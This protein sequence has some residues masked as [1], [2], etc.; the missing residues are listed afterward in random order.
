VAKFSFP[1]IV[2]NS[3][4]GLPMLREMSILRRKVDFSSTLVSAPP[5]DKT[6]PSQAWVGYTYTRTL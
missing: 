5:T 6:M 1:G 3:G 4:M 2:F